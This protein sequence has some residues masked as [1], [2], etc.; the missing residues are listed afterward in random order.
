MSI[1]VNVSPTTEFKFEKVLRQRDSL[2]LF[3]FLIVVER[4]LEVMMET[5]K[6]DLLKE[7]KIER[8]KVDLI[9]L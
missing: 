2:A 6:K 7:L 1:L 4:L 9:M 5:E 3:L 8:N